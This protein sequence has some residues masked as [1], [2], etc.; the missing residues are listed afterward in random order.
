VWYDLSQGMKRLR[1]ILLNVLTVLS[2]ILFAAT[3]V[4]WVRGYFTYEVI[5]FRGPCETAWIESSA[6]SLAT[7]AV[8]SSEPLWV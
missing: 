5:G 3:L 8:S 7:F 4:L 1:R 2:L 6:G